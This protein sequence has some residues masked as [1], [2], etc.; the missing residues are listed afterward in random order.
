M[1]FGTIPLAP[2]HRARGGKQQ[3]QSLLSFLEVQW[4]SS[5]WLWQLATQHQNTGLH[6]LENPLWS[7]HL[8]AGIQ[9]VK[10]MLAWI[11]KHCGA[12]G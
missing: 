2:C 11:Q 9:C 12:E 6:Q 1:V 10:H 3:P 8:E 4:Q 5:H 7:A